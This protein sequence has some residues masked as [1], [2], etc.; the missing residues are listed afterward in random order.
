MDDIDAQIIALLRENAR[1][2]FQDIGAQV[3]LSAPAVKRRVDRLQEAG[4]IRGYA[5]VVDPGKLGWETLAIVSL[6]C[7]GRM[8]AAEVQAVLAPHREVVSAYTVAGES[9]A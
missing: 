2:S 8:S 1:R 6:Y 3:A 7:E 5:A 4:V 9:A